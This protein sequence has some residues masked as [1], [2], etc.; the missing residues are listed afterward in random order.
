MDTP[1]PKLLIFIIAFN[2]EKTIEK[3]LQSVKEELFQKYNI[4][5]LIIN[6]AST[7]HTFETMKLLSADHPALPIKL[8]HNPVSVGYGGNQK[9]GFHYSIIH[10]FDYILLLHTEC[11]Y[12]ISIIHGL[13]TP[14]SE[15]RADFVLGSRNLVKKKNRRGIPIYKSMGNSL[16]K[17]FQNRMLH[18]RLSDYLSGYR[19][20]SVK[21]L[22]SIPFEKNSDN[23]IFDT[24]IIIQF[25]QS[26]YKIAEIPIPPYHSRR[27]NF[28][29]GVSYGAGIIRSVLLYKLH[30]LYILYQR[31][32]DIDAEHINYT[33][34]LGYQSSHTLAE[35][36]VAPNTHVMDLGCDKGFIATALKKKG[37]Y[38]EGVDMVI[39]ENVQFFDRFYP[40]DLNTVEKLGSLER[41][42]T[43]LI[44][45][46]I[47]H[48]MNPESFLDHIRSMSGRKFPDIIITT[49]N[50]AFISIRIGLLFSSFN[51]G[52]QGILDMTHKRLF[53]F[54]SLRR[55]LRQSGY[56][57]KETQGIPAPFPKA[58]GINRFSL[59]LVW[60][61]RMLIKISKS[62][63]S[64]QI[65]IKVTPTPRVNDLLEDSIREA[66][67]RNQN[68]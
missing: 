53:T 66:E 50:I 60:I 37:C 36:H 34:K 48:L 12:T 13:L 19:A 23:F 49:P 15:S 62:L 40:M 39:P 17:G 30:Q 3:S 7:D 4:E 59:F 16:L 5:I 9:L 65:F 8:L 57:I 35:M 6:D 47:E 63:F 2:A 29:R 67:I 32:F 52:K 44:L 61:N 25:L 42:D 10:R 20:F 21:A 33:P 64:Y 45:D 24:E 68:L 46:V 27:I 43:I 38:V 26:N 41:F 1:K 51:Y 14:L 31:N 28:F 58:L 56:I 55:L 18:T 11:N 22:E 54:R